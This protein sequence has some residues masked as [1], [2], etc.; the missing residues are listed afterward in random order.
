VRRVAVVLGLVAAMLP[1]SVRPAWAA[2]E[3]VGAPTS[4]R[5]QAREAHVVFTGVVSSI[6]TPA[7]FAH[8][9]FISFNVS[10][11]YE[12]GSGS[13]VTVTTPIARGSCHFDFLPRVR[14]T[15]FAD[16]DLST[17]ACSGNVRGVINA[18]GYGLVATPVTAGSGPFEVERSTDLSTPAWVAG[19][20]GF[21]LLVAGAIGLVARRTRLS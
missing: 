4:P 21:V 6:T 2:C 3:C 1:L 7:S 8:E 16:E 13:T 19:V 14:Y 9:A 11:V 18:E 10:T 17:G 15:V 5:D 20:I 12:G